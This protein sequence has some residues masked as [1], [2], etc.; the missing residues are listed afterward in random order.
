MEHSVQ[1]IDYHK[2]KVDGHK[3]ITVDSVEVKGKYVSENDLDQA[4]QTI[5]KEIGA[6]FAGSRCKI[7]IDESRVVCFEGASERVIVPQQK[8]GFTAF[9]SLVT[10][11]ERELDM[12]DKVT[13]DQD[14]QG[15]AY[16]EGSLATRFK[17]AVQHF[18]QSLGLGTLRDRVPPD[19]Q[20]YKN[21][22]TKILDDSVGGSPIGTQEVR[23]VDTLPIAATRL[24]DRIRSLQDTKKRALTEADQNSIQCELNSLQSQL[25]HV[26]TQGKRGW[27]P[28]G[29]FRAA[30]KDYWEADPKTEPYE[31][32]ASAAGKHIPAA[33]NLRTHAVKVG[34]VT[35][36]VV[37]YGAATD[38]RNGFTNLRE[39]K[40][41][42]NNLQKSDEKI[43][44]M[45]SELQSANA[46]IEKL[47]E[48]LDLAQ[49]KLKHSKGGSSR[50]QKMQ[51][52]VTDLQ[53]KL[54]LLL[55]RATVLPTRSLN[56]RR[57]KMAQKL[58]IALMEV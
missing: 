5:F 22:V 39:L 41:I 4:V 14:Q 8:I 50:G 9:R 47:A 29:A 24:A 30:I 48:R 42:S 56:L 57:L 1:R 38:L 19:E 55:G 46:T 54:G 44:Q 7:K 33:V 20:G 58:Y 23:R 40:E 16:V 35:K 25:D 53:A 36:E 45:K 17:E 6:N 49:V 28:S 13:D 34:E 10:L 21:L 2:Y 31:R 27:N 3:P 26:R 32:W 37:R 51:V 52:Q 12:A 15:K 43:A 18:F 11:M